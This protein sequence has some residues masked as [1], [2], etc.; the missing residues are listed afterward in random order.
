MRPYAYLCATVCGCKEWLRGCAGAF[1]ARRYVRVREC[2]CIYGVTLRLCGR[3]I[4]V[5]Y[6]RVLLCGACVCACAWRSGSRGL[7]QPSEENMIQ[8]SV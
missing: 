6:A 8:K 7:Y 5:I 2:A 4:A 1:D 3:V